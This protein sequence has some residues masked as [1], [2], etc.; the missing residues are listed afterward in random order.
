MQGDLPAH[1]AANVVHLASTAEHVNGR[2]YDER[3]PAQPNP[4]ALDNRDTA[5]AP[6]YQQRA[7]IPRKSIQRALIP[8]NGRGFKSPLLLLEARHERALCDFTCS[9]LWGCLTLSEISPAHVRR[10]WTGLL[11]NGVGP[12]TVAKSYR[13][14]RAVLNTAVDDE[15]DP[16][17]CMS[18]QGRW[19]GVGR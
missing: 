11:A 12:S 10:W 2:Y 4:L 16:T 15:S 1:G 9:Q 14:M 18:D 17:E 5:S 3:R 7:N 19:C 13:L 6:A 8:C